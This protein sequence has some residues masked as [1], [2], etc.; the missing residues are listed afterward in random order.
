[1]IT[2]FVL[3]GELFGVDALAGRSHC[4]DAVALDRCWVCELSLDEL[5]V[6][7]ENQPAVLSQLMLLFGEHLN[8]SR[9]RHQRF[10]SMPLVERLQQ[11]ATDL[12]QRLDSRLPPEE[13][14][15]WPGIGADEIASWLEIE[16]SAL[17]SLVDQCDHAAAT[18]GCRLLFS[19]IHSQQ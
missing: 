3:Q 12:Y 7:C 19:R 13:Q 15:G 1:M 17:H 8:A 5:E 4:L 9:E 11:L 14:R 16:P 10:Q 18:P 2:D 6:H